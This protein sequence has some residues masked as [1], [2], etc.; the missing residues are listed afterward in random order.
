MRKIYFLKACVFLF[1]LLGWSVNSNAQSSY[2]ATNSDYCSAYTEHLINVTYGDVNN[3]S[4]IEKY[5][6]FTSLNSIFS[7]G[8]SFNL[9]TTIANYWGDSYCKVY[10]WIDWNQDFVFGDDEKYVLAKAK[11]DVALSTTVDIPTDAASGTTRMRIVC[12]SGS[13][14]PT[15]CSADISGEIEDYSITVFGGG[16]LPIF[17]AS[18]LKTGANVEITFTQA[19]LGENITSYSWNFGEGAT[20]ATYEGATPPAVTYSTVGLKT[21]SL[22]VSDG[23]NTETNTKENYINIISGSAEYAQPQYFSAT[24]SYNT[25]KLTWLSPTA[26][27][28]MNN[29]EDFEAGLFPPAGWQVL[30]SDDLTSEPVELEEGTT[31][32][33]LVDLGHSGVYAAGV[34]YSVTKSNWLVTPSIE[35]GDAQQLSFWMNYYNSEWG[36]SQFD[37]M[38]K[39]GDTAWTNIQ[40]Y[41]A[42]SPS[43]EM[44][45][46]VTIDL[47]AYAGKTVK[48]AFVQT[49][50]NGYDIAI[51]DVAIESNTTKNVVSEKL[52]V[53]THKRNISSD[54]LP[55]TTKKPL[56]AKYNTPKSTRS[57]EEPTGYKVFLDRAQ[58]GDILAADVN[59]FTIENLSPGDH[60]LSVSAVYA[61][62]ES[63]M[64]EDTK[65]TTIEPA[66]SI[67]V[68]KIIANM[69]EDIQITGTVLGSYSSIEWNFGQDATP[70]TSSDLSTTVKYSSLGKKTVKLTINGEF[71]KEMTDLIDVKVGT[72]GVTPL[73]NVTAS[74]N[75]GDVT[76]K[77]PSLS[78]EVILSEGFE[79]AN[80][81]PAGWEIKSSV[82]LDGELVLP[83]VNDPLDKWF[84][85][86]ENSLG[87]DRYI[88]SGSYSA[89]I[90][91]SAPDFNWLIAPSVKVSEGHKLNFWLYYNGWSSYFPDFRVM[92]KADDTWEEV[93]YYTSGTASNEYETEI[94][95][96]LSSYAGKTVKVAFV[97]YGDYS[98]EL[99]IDDVTI[100]GTVPLSEDF[101]KLNIYR[102]N[103]LVKEITDATLNEWVDEGLITSEYKYY[104]TFVNTQ[105]EESFPCNDVLIKAY[106]KVEA[107]Y[108]QTF[109][110]DYSDWLFNKGE[111]AFKVGTDA[112]FAKDDYSIPAHEGKYVAVNTSDVNESYSSY[113]FASDIVAFSP[114]NLNGYEDVDLEFEYMADV[115]SFELVGRSST[116]GE[117]AVI[118]EMTTSAEWTSVKISLYTSF[119]KEGYQF[120]FRYTNS[121]EA[122]N[123]V[124]FDNVR[125]NAI[126]V[127]KPAIEALSSTSI[128]GGETVKLKDVSICYPAAT[129]REWKITPD[130]YEFVSGDANSEEI[131]IKFNELGVYS[132]TLDVTNS[133]GKESV[134]ETDFITVSEPFPAPISLTAN[135]DADTRTV[136][137]VWEK[138]EDSRA[139]VS[140]NVFRNDEQIANVSE[141]TYAD[142]LSDEAGEYE[143]FVTAV[144]ETPEGESVASNKVVVKVEKKT[145]TAIGDGM[146]L[147]VSA[148]PNPNKGTFTVNVSNANNVQWY[149]LDINGRVVNSGLSNN[150]NIVVSTDRAGV[151]M[152]KVIADQKTSIIKVIVK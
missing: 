118:K 105:G 76:V 62:G 92:V 66:I 74:A 109:E 23:T 91:Y 44:E 82:T 31:T 73:T 131:E 53:N 95:V 106:S 139:V 104:V 42:N 128:Y 2:C 63:Y 57:D 60:L 112:D 79:S 17:S 113:Y 50:T 18:P 40:S 32:W 132:V 51:D 136:A 75:Y 116:N 80:W 3:S 9:S 35:I 145:T 89:A 87:D 37:I 52:P 34:S 33:N 48:I 14:E 67:N 46:K 129:G 125:I 117:W 69:D 85:C 150:N 65:V 101:S 54:L 21:V 96:D 71:V 30:V 120:G 141:L 121:E 8:E 72:D 114:I 43:N 38:I 81:P 94:S 56:L 122:S 103:V 58:F 22:T 126:A 39:D 99:A 83:A 64:I 25:A 151:Y 149:L 68:D 45:S 90:N 146:V 36:G 41:D 88:H 78:S 134:T 143:Y 107:P 123:G 144:Y 152:V 49:F 138:P 29:P 133:V 142:Q 86:D 61:E 7:A 84:H 28:E 20:P 148:Y 5:G 47:A 108:A 24:A 127:P 124:A 137:V 100:T 12:L 119:L 15:P 16:V 93:L 97:Y 98:Y 13:T 111:F 140:Y 102:D 110:T 77:W 135:L 55:K 19:S 27:P 1:I 4:E 59:S 70:A 6:D 11:D 147:N 26:E 10:A 115:A 130:T